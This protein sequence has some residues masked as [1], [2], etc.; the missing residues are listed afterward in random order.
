MRR[1]DVAQVEHARGGEIVCV[2]QGVWGRCPL[3]GS[4]SGDGPNAA[5]DDACGLDMLGSLGLLGVELALGF[6][7]PSAVRRRPDAR[8]PEEQLTFSCYST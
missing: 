3:R 6:P 8:L 7:R 5:I 1:R 2:G 4:G